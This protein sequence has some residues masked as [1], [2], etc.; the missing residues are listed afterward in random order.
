MLS[1][2]VA[3]FG[4][5]FRNILLIAVL[6]LQVT[7]LREQRSVSVFYNTVFKNDTKPEILRGVQFDQKLS[8]VDTCSLAVPFD[9][10]VEGF[11]VLEYRAQA[12]DGET[13]D[14]V[15]ASLNQV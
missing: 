2:F 12:T 1:F 11:V 10:L 8:G 5:N 9:E 13:F 7:N 15:V 6:L 4:L 3:D 14:R